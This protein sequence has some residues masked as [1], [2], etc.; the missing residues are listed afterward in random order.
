MDTKIPTSEKAPFSPT[1]NLTPTPSHLGEVTDKHGSVV[2]SEL[3]A[4]SSNG[5][6]PAEQKRVL[7]KMD[8]RLIPML[9][10]LYL[11]SF[12]DRGNIGNAKIEG[13]TTDLHMTGQQY[14]WVGMSF[15]FLFFSFLPFA[16]FV[17][18]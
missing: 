7:R 9:V 3:Q 1:H 15:S 14:S 13:L 18:A 12:L 17:W 6:T 16:Q 4:G 5:L 8:M 2:D 11:M 10:A